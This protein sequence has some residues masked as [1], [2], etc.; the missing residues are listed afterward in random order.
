[1]NKF[2]DVKI[3][4]SK[5]TNIDFSKPN[6]FYSNLYGGFN[7]D[8]EEVKDVKIFS[9]SDFLSLFIEGNY[10]IE[11]ESG[12]LSIWGRRNKTE[13]KKMRILKIPVNLLY[14]VVFRPERTKDLYQDKISQIPEIKT[15]IGDDVATFRV[16]VSGNINSKDKLKVILKDIR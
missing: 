2:K 5:I 8:N 6:V 16:N 11:T 13:A 4:L 14:R 15:K 3:S 12:D 1:M 9:K 10:N 7:V